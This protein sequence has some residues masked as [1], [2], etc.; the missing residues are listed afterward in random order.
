MPSLLL[1]KLLIR[2]G[3]ARWLPPVRRLGHGA[4]GFLHYY[5]DRVLAAPH[6]A[7]AGTAPFLQIG[8]PDGI[9]LALGSPRCDLVP[10]ASTW[11][12][13]DR[14]GPPPPGGLPEL[15][16]AVADRLAAEQRLRVDPTQ[17]VLVTAG[18]AGALAVVLDTF[19]NPGDR[20]VLF[21]PTALLY[22]LM[23]R[24]RRARIRWVPTEMQAGRIRFPF[25]RLAR[26]LHRARLLLLACP[27]S[28]TG[29]VFTAEDLEQVAWW[30]ERHD[31]LLFSDKAFARY[32]YEG[33]PSS[34]G[35]LPTAQKRT[36][37]AG[38]ASKDYGLA[39]ARVGWLAGHRHLIGACALTAA[40]EGQ[41]VPTLCQQL[42]CTAL[43]QDRQTFAPLLT[44]LAARRR[45]VFDRL[46]ALGMRPSWP[47]GAFFFWVGVGHLGLSGAAF[48]ERL[49]REKKVL[50][51]PGHF[52]GPSGTAH[53][54]LS[55]LT[56]E[57]RLREGLAR[58]AEM[59]AGQGATKA[60]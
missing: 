46:Q 18:A 17:E 11:L 2:T 22:P 9:D 19:V 43:R 20:V 50:V 10:S 8:D 48:A 58:L 59:Q 55:Y 27:A 47:A 34:L 39:S 16:E 29:G 32:Q 56:D 41:L 23:V 3:L 31:V 13:A 25:D 40:L 36:L 24:Q 33:E 52:F 1:T 57:G 26:A 30:A 28:P 54:R 51:W 14:R 6:A 60:A 37:T 42:A 12:P 5:S 49:R 44:E 7:L 53:V 15:R 35:A 45:Y 4:A 21:D 38:T